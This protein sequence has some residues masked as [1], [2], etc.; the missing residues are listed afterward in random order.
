MSPHMMTK[1]QHQHRVVQGSEA[2]TWPSLGPSPGPLS[3]PCPRPAE[4][5]SSL[6]LAFTMT[7]AFQ[8]HRF[9]FW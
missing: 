9:L 5:A 8:S 3:V 4:G 7:K 1:L 6:R 2:L